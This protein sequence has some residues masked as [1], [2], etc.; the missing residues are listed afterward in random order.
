M[1]DTLF[2]LAL[3]PPLDVRL[4]ERYWLVEYDEIRRDNWLDTLARAGL[5]LWPGRVASLDGTGGLVNNLRVWENLILPAWYH[6]AEPLPALEESL[7]AL[8]AEVGIEAESAVGI[9]QSLPSALGREARQELALLRA[10]LTRPCCIVIDGD[11]HTFLAYG[12]GLACRELFDRIAAQ[13]AVFVVAAYPP[14]STGF[15]RLEAV[16]ASQLIVS[17]THEATEGY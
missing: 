8:F 11:W 15:Q 12:R 16:D 2:T 14:P 13:A 5:A 17:G 10:A 6:H 7:L 9:C 4:G 1:S 3:E